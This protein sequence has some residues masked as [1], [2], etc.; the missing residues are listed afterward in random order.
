MVV[1]L[2]GVVVFGGSLQEVQWK[3][4]YKEHNK[5]WTRQREGPYSC[6]EI[7]IKKNTSEVAVAKNNHH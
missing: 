1:R 7:L 3:W 2:V 5:E 6:G 4:F